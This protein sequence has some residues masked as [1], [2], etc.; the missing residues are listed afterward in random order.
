MKDLRKESLRGYPHYESGNWLAFY[1]YSF[2][3]TFF[4]YTH[5]PF[6]IIIF[7][8]LHGLINYLNIQGKL[9]LIMKSVKLKSSNTFSAIAGTCS[10]SFVH[11]KMRERTLVGWAKNG[12]RS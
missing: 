1:L 7:F 3:L 10:V 12:Q 2:H 11:G 5:L 8:S 9:E 6:F 4:I